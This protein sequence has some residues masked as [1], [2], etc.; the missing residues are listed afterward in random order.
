[1]LPRQNLQQG[2]F[3]GSVSTDEE[4]SGSWRNLEVEIDEERWLLLLDVVV[5]ELHSLDSDS[6]GGIFILLLF[7]FYCHCDLEFGIVMIVT[8]ESVNG[9]GNED[10]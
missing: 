5:G 10:D 1:M 9:N 8:I 7:L 3:T 4:A 2:R 6:V